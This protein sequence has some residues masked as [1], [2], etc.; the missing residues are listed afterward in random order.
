MSRRRQGRIVPKLVADR[1]RP[2]PANVV[3]RLLVGTVRVVV[4][5]QP[6]I[7]RVGDVNALRMETMAAGPANI[8]EFGTVKDLQGF[9]DLY[10][11]DAYQHVV[12][13]KAYP[14]FLITGG[15]NDPRVEPWEGA[16]LAA[17]LEEMPNHR[18]VLYR[19]EEQAGHGLGTTK[20]TR[21]AEEAD[22]TAFILW[23]A[24]VEAWQPQTAN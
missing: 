5:L 8:P 11:M 7:A 14:A 17:R 23:R 21:D 18:P 13:G 10:A 6:A 24:G 2:R 3:S 22:I 12:P 16:K 9:K 20:A 4:V 15:L 1:V 19:L